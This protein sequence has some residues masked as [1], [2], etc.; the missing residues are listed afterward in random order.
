MVESLSSTIAETFL[1]YAS[2]ANLAVSNVA[3]KYKLFEHM[4]HLSNLNDI[5]LC[6]NQY[7]IQCTCVVIEEISYF[8]SVTLLSNGSDSVGEIVMFKYWYL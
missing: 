5:T 1:I 8:S 3:L 2:V 6:K 4:F 7:D